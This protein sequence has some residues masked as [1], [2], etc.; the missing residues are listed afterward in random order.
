[1]LYNGY[2]NSFSENEHLVIKDT[3]S[4]L[5]KRSKK[6]LEWFHWIP[7]VLHF[8]EKSLFRMLFHIDPFQC[9]LIQFYISSTI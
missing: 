3:E 4:L 9:D 2:L 7:K 5:R 1:M 6:K 8:P